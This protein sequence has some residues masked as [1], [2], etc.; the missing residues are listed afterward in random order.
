[1]F[2]NGSK[3]VSSESLSSMVSGVVVVCFFLWDFFGVEKLSP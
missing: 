1:M 3:E 2:D